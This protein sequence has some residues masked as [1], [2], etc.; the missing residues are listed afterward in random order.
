MFFNT[1]RNLYNNIIIIYYVDLDFQHSSITILLL[2]ANH[3]G[4]L[5]QNKQFPYTYEYVIQYSSRWDYSSAYFLRA[6]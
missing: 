3:V 5:S 1:F 2:S 4:T 6:P